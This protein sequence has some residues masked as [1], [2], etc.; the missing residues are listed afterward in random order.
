MKD[1]GQQQ[2][3]EHYNTLKQRNSHTYSHKQKERGLRAGG[4]QALDWRVECE[5]VQVSFGVVCCPYCIITLLY[6]TVN[7]SV[8]STEL[9]PMRTS[10]IVVVVLSC[11]ALWFDSLLNRVVVAVVQ[12]QLTLLGGGMLTIGTV[13]TSCH[14]WSIALHDI[15]VSN[16]P[17][18]WQ[19]PYALRIGRLHIRV[20]NLLSLLSL[21]PGGLIRLGSLEFT[22]GF[23][24]KALESIEVEDTVVHLE[25]G[26]VDACGSVFSSQLSSARLKQGMIR[27]EPLN[28]QIGVRRLREFVLQRS[29][30]TWYEPGELTDDPRRSR[31]PQPKGALRLFTST[32]V[33]VNRVSSGDA[34]ACSE[35][36]T[37]FSVVS[38][39]DTLTLCFEHSEEHDAWR[40]AIEDAVKALAN[41]SSVPRHSNAPWME[42]LVAEDEA[43][44]VRW[45]RHAMRRRQRW[46]QRWQGAAETDGHKQSQQDE[47][48]WRVREHEEDK[49]A[50]KVPSQ[51]RSEAWDP[52][53]WWSHSLSQGAR[54]VEQRVIGAMEV[55]GESFEDVLEWQIG[56]LHLRGLEIVHNGAPFSLADE[57][58]E[59]RGFVGSCK[60]VP[61][62]PLH[63]PRHWTPR[64]ARCMR[65]FVCLCTD[66][67]SPCVTT[68]QG[69]SLSGIS[70][71]MAPRRI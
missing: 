61:A 25:D 15:R 32:F 60:I 62:P 3:R 16:P 40:D 69:L 38:G 68:P 59:L 26:A 39:A 7:A 29:L 4:R 35:G 65:S 41:G 1:T 6:S 36:D 13:K 31:P 33:E 22:L 53:R 70:C 12:H 37:S 27:K 5:F 66:S 45:R 64:P 8:H 54:W 17:G 34:E 18:A 30:L 44:K 9:V 21:H 24:I 10:A 11:C 43:R 20:N 23:R 63:Q 55:R 48:N 52:A 71:G 19:S 51:P 47:Q 50:S 28:G 57:G 49:E 46:R 56:R 14:N 58:W 67:C 42:A 2:N